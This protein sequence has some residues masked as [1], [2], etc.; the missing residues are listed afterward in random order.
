MNM[1]LVLRLPW[2]M[3][4]CR[5]SSNVP[6]LPSFL[7]MLQNR[8]LL[9]TL[10]MQW[11]TMPCACHAQRHLNVQKWSEHVLLHFDLEMRFPPQRRAL[12]RH[13]SSQK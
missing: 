4:L 8:H 3:Y 6:R 7:D 10:D 12:F 1:S 9:L 11:C 13:L 2:K 5:S